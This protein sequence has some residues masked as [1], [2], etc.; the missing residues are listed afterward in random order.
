MAQY[1]GSFCGSCS[2]LAIIGFTAWYLSY[3]RTVDDI[4]LT[5]LFLSRSPT[6]LHCGPCQFFNLYLG[7]KNLLIAPDYYFL[8]IS[9]VVVWSKNFVI[10]WSGLETKPTI[11]SLQN[12]KKEKKYIKKNKRKNPRFLSKFQ[13]NHMGSG[14]GAGLNGGTGTALSSNRQRNDNSYHCSIK[15]N[16]KVTSSCQRTPHVFYRLFSN[17]SI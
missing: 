16:D 1:Y 13:I 7:T 2:G 9:L 3:V 14:Q 6:Y 5:H 8:S 17:F 12:E 15:M 11:P 10:S 4:L